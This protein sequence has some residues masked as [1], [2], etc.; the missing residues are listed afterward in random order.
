MTEQSQTEYN[1][2]FVTEN[3]EHLWL[4]PQESLNISDDWRDPNW[5]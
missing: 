4:E 3:K 1:Q 2:S 5:T